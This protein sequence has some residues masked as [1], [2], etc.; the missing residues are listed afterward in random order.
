MFTTV[1]IVATRHPVGSSLLSPVAPCPICP[2]VLVPIV[3]V[4][5]TPHD[6]CH[7]PL[8]CDGSPPHPIPMLSLSS[9]A[10]ASTL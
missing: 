7:P 9:V 4:L 3:V 8:G 5:C 10:P 6:R 1:K 2:H